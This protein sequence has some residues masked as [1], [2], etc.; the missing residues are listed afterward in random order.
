MKVVSKS[1]FLSVKFSIHVIPDFS[2]TST[3]A[4][5]SPCIPKQQKLMCSSDN[6][7]NHIF[8]KQN[9]WENMLSQSLVK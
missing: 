5:F 2:F 7:A 3:K 8:R 1:I 4:C 6:V 9:T